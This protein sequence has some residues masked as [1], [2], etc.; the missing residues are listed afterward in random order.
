MLTAAATF[1]GF[2]SA[3]FY[4]LLGERLRN[5]VGSPVS[6]TDEGDFR[7]ETGAAVKVPAASFIIAIDRA[8]VLSLRY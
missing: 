1:V 5:A 7:F 6:E 4:C 2:S 3:G 8:P